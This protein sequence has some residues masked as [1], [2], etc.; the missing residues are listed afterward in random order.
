MPHDVKAQSLGMKLTREQQFINGG[1][2]PIKTVPR[3]AVKNDAIE[4]ARQIFNE[5]WFDDTYCVRGIEC[6]SNYRYEYN[7]DKDT[8]NQNPHHDWA[9]NGADAFMQFAQGFVITEEYKPLPQGRKRHR[10]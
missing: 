8:H 7:D 6:L 2:K 5:V 1:V 4:M 9:S 10:A 3:I